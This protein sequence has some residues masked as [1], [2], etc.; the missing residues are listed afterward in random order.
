MRLRRM[1]FHGALWLQ[2]TARN[3][4]SLPVLFPCRETLLSFATCVRHGLL[5]NLLS[6]GTNP[7]YNCRD[8]PLWWLQ[9]VQ[10][11]PLRVE[12]SVSHFAHFPGLLSDGS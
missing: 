4:T 8:A 5:P 10:V 12:V 11:G 7:R 3:C 9:S 6:G 2:L 1:Y